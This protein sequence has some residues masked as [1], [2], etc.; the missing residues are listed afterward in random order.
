MASVKVSCLGYTLNHYRFCVYIKHTLAINSRPAPMYLI[1]T[2][3]ELS[4]IRTL[5][6]HVV[7]K[8]TA[9]WCKPCEALSPILEDL[10]QRTREPCAFAAVDVDAAPELAGQFGV[11]QIPHVIVLEYGVQVPGV[12]R[13][14][15]N[16]GGH[17]QMC[18]FRSK[19]C[20]Q[21]R[22]RRSVKRN[23]ENPCVRTVMCLILPKFHHQL[24]WTPT[25]AGTQG[26]GTDERAARRHF[27]AA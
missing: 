17:V 5:H 1:K 14:A 9:S 22:G 13:N 8:F 12:K 24:D 25:L 19:F 18:A 16:L 15:K 3:D 6:K 7:L 4:N 2:T 27:P 26:D 21:L 20:I 23:A 10:Q 11:S